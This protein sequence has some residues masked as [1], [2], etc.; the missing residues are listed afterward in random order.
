MF[1]SDF[2]NN[3]GRLQHFKRCIQIIG[4]IILSRL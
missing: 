4:T 2:D 1:H 3:I